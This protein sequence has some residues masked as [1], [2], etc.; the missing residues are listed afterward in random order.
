MYPPPIRHRPR[1]RH[2]HSTPMPQPTD[3]QFLEE[4][5]QLF[6]S[7]AGAEVCDVIII[8]KDSNKIPACRAILA[9]RS[10][11]F[12]KLFFSG[13]QEKN[14]GEVAVGFSERIMRFILEFSYSG[15]CSLTER[16]DMKFKANHT[17]PYIDVADLV[18][19]AAAFDYCEMTTFRQICIELLESLGERYVSTSC[20][21]ME[22]IVRNHSPP[23]FATAKR[24]ILRGLC[25]DPRDAFKLPD[26]VVSKSSRKYTLGKDQKQHGILRLSADT[27]E[28][29]F[30]NHFAGDDHEYLFQ[31][32]YY[33]ATNGDM[34]QCGSNHPTASEQNSEDSDDCARDAR[35]Q[36]AKRLCRHLDFACMRIMFLRDYV[37]PTTL[38]DWEALKSI[39]W[40]HATKNAEVVQSY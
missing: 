3:S 20:T 37:E 25:A 23:S 1:A 2:S 27:I 40:F 35:W 21:A 38:L 12:K 26:C 39:L 33:W 28:Q 13:F 4:T 19:L 8:T 17:M 18:D 24:A 30:D 34:L 11:Y 5:S 15:K 6:L 36:H 9:I 7:E 16:I 31:A 14:E 29:V 32:L 10:P 22:A